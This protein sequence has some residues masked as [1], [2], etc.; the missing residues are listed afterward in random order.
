MVVFCVSVEFMFPFLCT[1]TAA[2]Y[3]NYDIQLAKSMLSS[4]CQNKRTRSGFGLEIIVL[5]A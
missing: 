4:Q 3:N 5:T 2:G 1:V